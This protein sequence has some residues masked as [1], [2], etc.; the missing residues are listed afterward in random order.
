MDSFC[1]RKIELRLIIFFLLNDKFCIFQIVNNLH[2]VLKFVTNQYKI[3][4]IP[5][6]LYH[7]TQQER[8][9]LVKNIHR[10]KGTLQIHPVVITSFEIAMR[11]RN[12][13]QVLVSMEFFV[14]HKPHFSQFI[15]LSHHLVTFV[16]FFLPPDGN[17]GLCS[18]DSFRNQKLA[19]TD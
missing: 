10:R 17:S 9:K 18:T 13:L 3:F 6:M 4:Q 11:D 16:D 5:T 2:F 7:G 15:A 19:L 1:Y 8:R 14:I 12:A